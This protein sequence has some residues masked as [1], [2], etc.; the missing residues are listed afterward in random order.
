MSSPT[1]SAEGASNLGDNASS[2]EPFIRDSI[3]QAE[4]LWHA[5]A[6]HQCIFRFG[7]LSIAVRF[8]GGH[9]EA[10]VCPV[11]EHLKTENGAESA[12]AIVYVLVS[13]K[14]HQPPPPDHWPFPEESKEDYQRVCWRP[15]DGLALS[16]DDARGIW[17]LFDLRSGKGLY[18]LGNE[19]N[20]PY[21]EA[22]SPL[23]H[24]I[25][26]ASV[27]ADQAMVH[28]AAIGCDGKGV[29]LAGAGGSGKSTLTAA[30]ISCGWQTTG[31]DFVLVSKPPEPVSYPI[32]DVMKLTG[33]AESLFSEQS[34]MALN[35]GRKPGEKALI[36]MSASAAENFVR[37]LPIHAIFSLVLTGENTSRIEALS[38]VATVAALAPSTM[39]I[40]RTAMPE[41]LEQCSMLARNLPTYRLLLGKDPLEGLR[42]LE[43]FMRQDN[44][45]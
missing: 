20:L 36:P 39:N 8:I 27:R 34:A 28:G 6:G 40:L 23:R 35:P 33:M 30:G 19:D 37:S 38:K 7:A 26:W 32:F 13:D 5:R 22:G 2:L 45:G 11:L 43:G 41:T 1:S 16:S 17:H 24:F 14:L 18:W 44:W 31:D 4:R 42:T 10:V 9:G 12:N 29:L 25:H 3:A 21:W 15:R